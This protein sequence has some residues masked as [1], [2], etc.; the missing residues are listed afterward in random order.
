[1]WFQ[2]AGKGDVG[3]C[4]WQVTIPIPG[5][6]EIPFGIAWDP[7]RG[8]GIWCWKSAWS[9]RWRWDDVDGAA[10]RIVLGGKEGSSPFPERSGIS[11][12]E[13]DPC[14][15]EIPELLP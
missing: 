12:G 5:L 4:Q 2:R 9:K 6:A 7:F 15:E 14:L 13:V 1:M 10:P 3:L 11:L 8:D